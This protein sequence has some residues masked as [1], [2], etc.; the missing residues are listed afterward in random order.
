VSDLFSIL[1]AVA[2]VLSAIYML[3]VASK[4]LG[5]VSEALARV[6]LRNDGVVRTQTEAA[7]A[8]RTHKNAIFMVLS[9]IICPLILILAKLGGG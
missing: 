9:L 5:I 3:I 6:V 8:Y 4:S 7:E 2:F 1:F